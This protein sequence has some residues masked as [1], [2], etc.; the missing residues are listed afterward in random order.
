MTSPKKAGFGAYAFAPLMVIIGFG[1]VSLVFAFILKETSPIPVFVAFAVVMAVGMSLQSH[2]PPK[3]KMAAR[4]VSM[5]FIGLVLMVLA[6]ILGRSNLQIEGFFFYLYSGVFGGAIVHFGIAKIAGPIVFGRNW[7]GWGCWTAMILD[8]LPYKKNLSRKKGPVSY[9]RYVLLFVTIL[10]TATLFFGMKYTII[11]TNPEAAESGVGTITE[12]LWFVVGNAV[13][14][15]AGISLAIALKDN[16]AFCKYV[17]P[18]SVLFKTANRFSLLRIKGDRTR[19]TSCN[20]CVEACPMDVNIPKYI[21]G[22]QRVASTECILC[23]KCIP[24]CPLAALKAS[25]GFDMAHKDYL[26]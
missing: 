7:C 6:G 2:L 11:A 17:C 21:H 4:L 5:F 18:V 19:C 23:L 8:L 14:Y 12:M 15:L 10:L 25:V 16:R 20:S 3:G 1:V 26:R 22:N 13:Y 9:I 24:A